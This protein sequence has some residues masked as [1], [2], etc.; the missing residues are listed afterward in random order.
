MAP[1]VV[2]FMIQFCLIVDNET[3]EIEIDRGEEKID[4]IYEKRFPGLG[5]LC[6]F[7]FPSCVMPFFRLSQGLNMPPGL[8]L[9]APDGAEK[10]DRSLVLTIGDKLSSQ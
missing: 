4:R 10:H 8:C 3:P 7:Q 2:I 1:L 9:G 6:P 5:S